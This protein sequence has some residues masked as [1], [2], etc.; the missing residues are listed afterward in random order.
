MSG[1]TINGKAVTLSTTNP[2][3][4]IDTGTTLI[5][6]P[7]DDVVAFYNAIKGSVDL[8]SSQPGFYGYRM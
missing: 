6:G 2:L 7:H 4:A 1:L 3:S 8:G 5:G